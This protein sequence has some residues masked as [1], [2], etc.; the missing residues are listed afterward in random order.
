MTNETAMSVTVVTAT[1][2][3][4]SQTPSVIEDAD[5]KSDKPSPPPSE[6]TALNALK[7]FACAICNYRTSFKSNLHKHI[8]THG[9]VKECLC[10]ICGYKCFFKAT[11]KKHFRIHT[12]D[13]PF[14]CSY[15]TYRCSFKSN[16]VRH[17]KKHTGEEKKFACEHCEYRC[18]LKQSFVI[19]MR[20]HT[21]EKPFVCNVCGY[22]CT[23]NSNLMQHMNSHSGEKPYGCNFCD[24]Q[25]STRSNLVRHRKT[26]TKSKQ[27]G[28]DSDQNQNNNLGHEHFL[29]FEDVEKADKVVQSNLIERKDKITVIERKVEEQVSELQSIQYAL[30]QTCVSADYCSQSPGESDHCDTDDYR[31]ESPDKSIETFVKPHLEYRPD[32]DALMHR[33][34]YLVR[35]VLRDVVALEPKSQPLQETDALRYRS[36]PIEMVP[37]K[38]F[39]IAL[40]QNEMLRWESFVK[41]MLRHV[42]G[43]DYRLEAPGKP[44]V[45][46][47]TYGF[48]LE[49]LNRVS[50]GFGYQTEAP[51]K[52]VDIFQPSATYSFSKPVLQ[53]VKSFDML[54][55]AEPLEYRL[56]SLAQPVAQENGGS[57]YRSEALTHM[58]AQSECGLV[59]PVLHEMAPSPLQSEFEYRKASD[60]L[61]YKFDTSANPIS[62]ETDVNCRTEVSTPYEA[63]PLPQQ[64]D[65]LESVLQENKH[66]TTPKCDEM[67]LS[68]EP[69]DPPLEKD[70]LKPHSCDSCTYRCN[71]RSNLLK[72]MKMHTGK[73][74]FLCNV[75][76]YK[77]YFRA[78]LKKHERIHSGE[79][80]FACT[81]CDYRCCFQSNLVRHVRTH[82]G[83]D[84]KYS[85]TLCDY[86]CPVRQSLVSH[87]KKH[88]GEKPFKCTVCD[89]R[90]ALKSN[91]VQHMNT[92]TGERTY[93]CDTCDN[94]YSTRSNLIRHRRIHTEDKQYECSSCD[95]KTLYK[96]HLT[97]HM[98]RRSHSSQV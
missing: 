9:G 79:Q 86:R 22:R 67:P 29:K 17:M 83:Q 95:Y 97:K 8:R 10:N 91:M 93:T 70:A 27:D 50:N 28:K 49:S 90:C 48:K 7:K 2:D 26:H 72:H 36:E 54:Q 1:S 37:P 98:T 66:S 12:G 62:C 5:E 14:L 35:P 3:Q 76:G 4:Q 94:K 74:E 82:T 40:H 71:S 84:K 41:P 31:A 38:P 11:L 24:K 80:P 44:D 78:T 64:T 6:K 25:Y 53:E 51:P 61:D 77:C 42:E 55:P 73:K 56:T 59:K 57:D 89:Y 39:D 21:G 32:V 58:S 43:L 88:T 30:P 92:H 47:Q 13:Q 63:Q 19:H 45:F 81:M 87:M 34:E 85:C 23:L 96:G 68:P 20:K 46:A 75:C 15:C 52:P 18:A 65:S 69:P 60:V 16:L 33:P